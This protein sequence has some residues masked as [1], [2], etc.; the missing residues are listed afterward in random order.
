M[1]AEL[2]V[3]RFY[4]MQTFGG[5][6]DKKRSHWKELWPIFSWQEGK[7]EGSLN[8]TVFDLAGTYV[9]LLQNFWEAAK[10]CSGKLVSTFLYM[11]LTTESRRLSV[12]DRQPSRAVATCMKIQRCIPHLLWAEKW[13]I[14]S[15]EILIGL[16]ATLFLAQK[17]IHIFTY[18]DTICDF[19]IPA[20]LWWVRFNSCVLLSIHPSD[21]ISH[22][23]DS[24]SFNRYLP[25]GGGMAQ[26]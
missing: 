20:E 2:S 13:G 24:G 3:W 26:W 15:S 11:P 4:K 23:G 9:F 25:W 14:L 5:H 21:S 18:R 6:R 17:V 16:N 1:Q 10:I 7:S 22:I 19:V 8:W 12:T